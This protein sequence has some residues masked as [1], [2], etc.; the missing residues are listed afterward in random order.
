MRLYGM[1]WYGMVWESI[2]RCV[3]CSWS[4]E[5]ATRAVLSVPSTQTPYVF[6]VC[7]SSAAL[8][9]ILMH[10]FSALHCTVLLMDSTC[11]SQVTI[12]PVC[13]HGLYAVQ[14]VEYVIIM[15]MT[16]VLQAIY[17]IEGD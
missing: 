16:A 9:L 11:D 17:I 14:A 6:R 10:S 7:D 12:A 2:L 4:T 3:C 5:S 1:V 13:E 15:S 8:I